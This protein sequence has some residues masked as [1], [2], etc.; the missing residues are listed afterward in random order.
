MKT[1]T[2]EFQVYSF[3]ELSPEAKKKALEDFRDIDTND[4]YWSTRLIEDVIAPKLEANGFIKPD[5]SF[6]G[7]GSQGDGASFTVDSIDIGLLGKALNYP[8][9]DIDI[10][11]E[12]MIDGTVTATITR[13]NNGHYV[14]ESMCS[15]DL[16]VDWGMQSEQEAESLS[17]ICDLFAEQAENLRYKLCKQAYSALSDEY[18]ELTS[19]THV[20][21]YI[22]ENDIHFLADGSTFND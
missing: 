17:V 2:K 15:F 9:A 16:D 8:Q 14:H 11:A 18:T 19:D 10:I 1:I 20:Q 4:S 12:A 22:E 7:F 3:A 13:S 5:V 21:E 6:S